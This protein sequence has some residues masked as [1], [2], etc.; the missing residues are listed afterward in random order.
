[1]K[2]ILIVAALFASAAQAQTDNLDR[3]PVEATTVKGEK[4][5]LYPTGKWEYVDTAKAAEAKKLAEQYPENKVRPI[6]AQ[7][8]WFPGSRTVMPG[9]KDYN[10]GSL[11][12]R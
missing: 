5:H 2:K 4:V 10:R 7:G 3:T 11:M 8:G 9:D 1:M 6:D 12:K